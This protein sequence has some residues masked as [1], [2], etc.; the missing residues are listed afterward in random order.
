[1]LKSYPYMI[2]YETIMAEILVFI[3]HELKLIEMINFIYLSY[4]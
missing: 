4:K 2:S 1:M 3:N